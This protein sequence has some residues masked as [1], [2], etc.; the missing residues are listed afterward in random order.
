MGLFEPSKC[1]YYRTLKIK[2]DEELQRKE[3]AMSMI[4]TINQLKILAFIKTFIEKNSYPP[5]V[6]EVADEFSVSVKGAQDHLKA[7]Q[8]KGYIKSEY[9][10]PRTITIIKE[11]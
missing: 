9:R 7:L 11:V 1:P 4:A 10:K 6:R 3:E 8:R 2:I 5:T